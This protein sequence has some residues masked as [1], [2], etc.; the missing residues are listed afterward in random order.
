MLI[1]QC[2]SKVSIQTNFFDATLLDRT[3][4]QKL[5]QLLL[6]GAFFMLLSRD[7]AVTLNKLS[8]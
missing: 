2:Y 5:F 7:H 4:K 6:Y 3:N 1:W 8:L